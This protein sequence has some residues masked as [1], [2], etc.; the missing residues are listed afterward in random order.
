MSDPWVELDWF[1]VKNMQHLRA[2]RELQRT[3]FWPEGFIQPHMSL[4]H[5]WDYIIKSKLADA[6]LEVKLTAFGE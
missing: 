6:Y 2:F 4:P 1:D 3:G 5:M